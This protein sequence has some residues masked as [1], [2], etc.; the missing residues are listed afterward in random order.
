MSN[1]TV[2]QQLVARVAIQF[3]YIHDSLLY[4]RLLKK[5]CDVASFKMVRRAPGYVSNN[6]PDRSIC[7]DFFIIKTNCSFYRLI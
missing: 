1:V 6:A 5:T 3:V 2:L 7:G 4:T